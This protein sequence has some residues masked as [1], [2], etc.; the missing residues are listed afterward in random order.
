MS[1]MQPT[2]TQWSWH[3]D[4]DRIEPSV[5]PEFETA[6]TIVQRSGMPRARGSFALRCAARE[7]LVQTKV[8][9]DGATKLRYLFARN[10]GARRY[11]R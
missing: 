3:D 1:L 7:G 6:S 10:C 4:W 5:R 9:A 2:D 11:G 8:G